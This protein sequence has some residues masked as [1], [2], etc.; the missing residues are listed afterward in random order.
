M[1]LTLKTLVIGLVP[2]LVVGGLAYLIVNFL[3]GL[4]I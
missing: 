3:I 2:Y 4:C 1:K